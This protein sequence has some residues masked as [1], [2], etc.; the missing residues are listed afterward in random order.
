MVKKNRAEKEGE[1]RGETK[2]KK[3]EK[4]RK[5]QRV[6]E[7]R[8]EERE[9]NSWMIKSMSTLKVTPVAEWRFQVSVQHYIN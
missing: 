3:V 6:E 9:E 5:E 2:E 1:G 7:E 4:R 8:D